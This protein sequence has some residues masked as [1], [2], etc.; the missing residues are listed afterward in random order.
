MSAHRSAVLLTGFGAF[1][2]VPDNA[3]ARLVAALSEAARRRFAARFVAD[4]LPVEWAAAPQ[5]LSQ[6][7]A[8]HRPQVALHFGVSHEAQGFAIERCG[9]NTC[10]ATPDATGALPKLAHLDPDGPPARTASLPVEC[11]VARLAALGLP[12]YVSE[13]AGTYLCNALLYHSLGAGTTPDGSRLTG[14]VHIPAELAGSGGGS[15]TTLHRLDWDGALAG[16]LEIVAVCL[17][18]VAAL[19]RIG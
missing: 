11:L 10:A 2:G 7:L 19:E 12:A 5:R 13:S 1:P 15:R 16:G 18:E 8:A 3:T 4:V 9:R 6:L 14:F 17:E